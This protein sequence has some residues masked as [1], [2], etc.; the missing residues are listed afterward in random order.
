MDG[1]LLGLGGGIDE[2]PGMGLESVGSP[3][4]SDSGSGAVTV[5]L[6]RISAGAPDRVADAVPPVRGRRGETKAA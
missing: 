5:S 1:A 3:G 6:S 4:N 2:M